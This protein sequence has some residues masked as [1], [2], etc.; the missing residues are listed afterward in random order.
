M[1]IDEACV[2]VLD[3]HSS[4]HIKGTEV[5]KGK[6]ILY[7][8]SPVINY[9]EGIDGYAKFRGELSLLSFVNLDSKTGMT[10]SLRMSLMHM[11][12]FQLLPASREDA[13]W[14]RKML[15]YERKNLGTKFGINENNAIIMTSNSS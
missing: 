13:I 1:L 9:Y 8:C 5:Y 4:H 6:L 10:N 15:N 7:G 14:I 3:G 2:D 12:R 11:K